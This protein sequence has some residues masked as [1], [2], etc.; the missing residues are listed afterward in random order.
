MS[1]NSEKP[2]PTP[3]DGETEIPI[4]EA[5]TAGLEEAPTEAAEDPPAGGEAEIQPGTP[6]EW[7]Q[8]REEAAKAREYWDRLL[9]M[10]ADLE[11]FK[12]R[13]ARERQDIQ[14]YANE[15]LLEQLLP[16]V[17]NFEAAA[18]AARNADAVGIESL[19]KGVEMILS[20]LKGVLRENGL[21][22]IDAQGKPFDPNLHEAMAQEP[23][24]SV[25]E[26]HVLRQVR[27]GY[28]LRDR[29]LRPASVVVARPPAA[30]EK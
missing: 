26:E 2:D 4:E 17:D 16:V 22:E 14:R 3:L 8:L 12:K 24:D 27:K 9:R 13:A 11:N 30:G 19:Q 10:T 20:Q 15:S 6:G 21:E 28:K 25:P 18:A 23:S 29:L 7:R 1:Q 5:E